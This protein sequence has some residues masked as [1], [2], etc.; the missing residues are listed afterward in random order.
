MSFIYK[1]KFR[2][3]NFKKKILYKQKISRKIFQKTFGKIAKKENIVFN[4]SLKEN[5]EEENNPLHAIIAGFLDNF[6]A[7]FQRF[8]IS[9]RIVERMF[10]KN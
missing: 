2:K 6:L 8:L 7:K 10:E 5:L 9:A 4:E 3:K 1:N